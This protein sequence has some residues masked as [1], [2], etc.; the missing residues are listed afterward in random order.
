MSDEEKEHRGEMLRDAY[1]IDVVEEQIVATAEMSARKAAEK[2]WNENVPEPVF[3][4]TEAGEVEINKTSIEDSLAHR[5]G[6]AKL[7]AITSLV[8]G[9]ENAAYLGTLP[10]FVR[11]EGVNNHYFAFSINYKA[12]CFVEPCK[13]PTKTFVCT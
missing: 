2:W 11:Q 4:D 1:A 12:M 9:F 6:Q 13:M 7:D 3:S 8:D 10:D 5:Y